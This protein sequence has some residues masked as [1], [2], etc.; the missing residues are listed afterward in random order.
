MTL[1]ELEAK[2]IVIGRISDSELGNKYIACYGR[3]TAGGVRADSS[4]YFLGDTALAAALDCY[5]ESGSKERSPDSA[6]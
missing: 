3:I 2:G 5:I 1:E 4:E 6:D